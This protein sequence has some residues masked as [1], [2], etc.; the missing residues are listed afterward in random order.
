ME[1][2]QEL[3]VTGKSN[4][5]KKISKWFT[6]LFII[7]WV[8]IH[9]MPSPTPESIVNEAFE[10]SD[11]DILIKYYENAKEEDKQ[12]TVDLFIKTW[13]TK[14]NKAV[15][16]DYDNYV[17][18]KSNLKEEQNL[19][20]MLAFPLKVGGEPAEDAKVF[21]EMLQSYLNSRQVFIASCEQFQEKHGYYPGKGEYYP[22]EIDIF[23]VNKLSNTKNIYFGCSYKY[24][25]GS[26]YPD[27]REKYL[28]DFNH[29]KG[30]TASQG[31][32]TY[33]VVRVGAENV[34]NEQGF[35]EGINK[36]KVITFKEAN[37]TLMLRLDYDPA[38][39][40]NYYLRLKM[41]DY[42]YL[43]GLGDP[44]KY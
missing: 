5:I 40:D 2:N 38:L 41:E 39:K 26:P 4:V 7:A 16:E 32:G 21:E 6:I 23:L 29:V 3:Q 27:N 13:A 20:N 10:K 35:T 30:I 33:Y 11:A 28:L 25:M 42:F 19:M 31:I 43:H 34:E 24:I 15:N 22:E 1:E 36:Y 18:G 12:K 17:L 9:L 44:R 14:T 8:I 37:D